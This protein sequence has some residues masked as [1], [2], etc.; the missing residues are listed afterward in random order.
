MNVVTSA[1]CGV[2]SVPSIVIPLIPLLFLNK[3]LKMSAHTYKY[4]VIDGFLVCIP[5]SLDYSERKS[6]CSTL[7]IE[8]LSKFSMQHI[9]GLK[10]N[11]FYALLMKVQNNAFSNSTDTKSV[12][13]LSF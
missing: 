1:Y 8:Y 13:I 2:Y 3:I 4:R 9:D 6:F 10:L 7:D 12:I 11:I 5:C